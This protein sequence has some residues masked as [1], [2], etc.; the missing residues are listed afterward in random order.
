MAT[1]VDMGRCW[2]NRT[3]AFGSPTRCHSRV[4]ADH[5]HIGLCD[6]CRDSLRGVDQPR[7]AEAA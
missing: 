3:N 2:A 4:P 1:P 5:D 6:Q 7:E